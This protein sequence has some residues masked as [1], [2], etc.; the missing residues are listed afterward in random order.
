MDV[1]ESLD[2]LLGDV[3]DFMLLQLFSPFFAFGHEL[4]EILF[5]ILEDEVRLIDDTYDL[6]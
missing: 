4:I 5:D 1:D 6:F 2:E 3:P